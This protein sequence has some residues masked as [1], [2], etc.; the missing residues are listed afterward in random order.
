MTRSLLRIYSIP[1]RLFLQLTRIA[2]LNWVET[3]REEIMKVIISIMLMMMQTRI[4][5]MIKNTNKQ[6]K[7][8]V[9]LPMLLV[10]HQICLE[11]VVLEMRLKGIPEWLP[12]K[13]NW[14]VSVAKQVSSRRLDIKLE[15]S[16]TWMKMMMMT[17]TKKLIWRVFSNWVHPTCHIIS[18]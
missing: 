3:S 18:I 7:Y 11:V 2:H 5:K 14:W 12:W 9:L 8:L 15:F 16:L 6:A 10:E 4:N 1:I 13:K 17:R